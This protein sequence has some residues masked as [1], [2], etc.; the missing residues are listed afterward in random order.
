MGAL[1]VDL[2][3]DLNTMDETGLPWTF[4]DRASDPSRIIPGR[5][6]VVGSGA[7]V[8]VALVVDVGV[9]DDALVHVQPLRGSVEFNAHLLEENPGV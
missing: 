9:G 1:D 2:P 8:A 6:I 5:H 7:A 4:L 3:L